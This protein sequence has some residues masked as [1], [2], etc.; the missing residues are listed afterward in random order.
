[1]HADIPFIVNVGNDATPIKLINSL[2]QGIFLP[3]IN[4][5]L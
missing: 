1:M 5:L 4:S 2:L 3:G